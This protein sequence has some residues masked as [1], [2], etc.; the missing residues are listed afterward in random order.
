MSGDPAFFYLST[1]SQ[2]QGIPSLNINDRYEANQFM[3]NSGC[4]SPAE[5][6]MI[7]LIWEKMGFV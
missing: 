4:Y 5:Q 7:S 1:Q 6:A 2:R 3:M